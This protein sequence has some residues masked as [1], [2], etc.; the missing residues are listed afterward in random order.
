MDH[1]HKAAACCLALIGATSAAFGGDVERGKRLAQL[2]CAACHIIGPGPQNE[3]AE[4]PPFEVI[5]RKWSFNADALVF[6]LVG[7]H[8]KMNFGLTRPEADDVAAYIATL[9]K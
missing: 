1:F 3:V 7:P 2:R 6:A 9:A 5:G 4:S 8:R